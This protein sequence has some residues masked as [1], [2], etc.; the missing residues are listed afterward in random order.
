MCHINCRIK[1]LLKFFLRKYEYDL[2]CMGLTEH[3]MLD[4][5]SFNYENGKGYKN[6]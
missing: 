4:H 5:A 2:P 6:E 1:K 3:V